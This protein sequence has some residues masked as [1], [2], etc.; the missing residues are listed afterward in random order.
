MTISDG[1][2]AATSGVGQGRCPGPGDHS[3][4]AVGAPSTGAAI[5]AGLGIG[6]LDTAEDGLAVVLELARPVQPDSA[7]T[8]EYSG[9]RKHW[10]TVRG[11]D[12]PTFAG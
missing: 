10:A 3:L 1:E 4:T 6:M 5:L 7:V 12:F 8:A 2:P 11:S 9:L